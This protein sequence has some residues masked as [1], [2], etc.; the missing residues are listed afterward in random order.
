M[1]SRSP[2][3]PTPTSTAHNG[4]L[5]NSRL[6]RAGEVRRNAHICTANAKTVQASARYSVSAQSDPDIRTADPNCP[7]RLAATAPR[8]ATVANWTKVVAAAS[9]CRRTAVRS[10]TVTCTARSTAAAATSTSPAPGAAKPPDWVSRTQPST[11]VPA[12]G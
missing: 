7:P 11:A 5:P 8:T 1:V 9:V 4:S 12:A 3:N 6:T 2:A 10:M